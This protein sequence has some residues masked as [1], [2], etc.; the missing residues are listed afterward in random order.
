[1]A[2][3]YYMLYVDCYEMYMVLASQNLHSIKLTILKMKI[4]AQV[5]TAKQNWKGNLLCFQTNCYAEASTTRSFIFLLVR[6]AI[7]ITISIMATLLMT[8]QPKDIPREI[9]EVMTFPLNDELDG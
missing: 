1:M 8:I 7:N 4:S 5:S 6:L 9:R 3:V 2:S